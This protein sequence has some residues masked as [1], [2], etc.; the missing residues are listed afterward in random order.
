MSQHSIYTVF[1][2]AYRTLMGG[3]DC[4]V[5][6]EFCAVD[7]D[8]VLNILKAEGYL[9]W[10]EER[11]E[12]TNRFLVIEPYRDV[13]KC[14]IKVSNP[15]DRSQSHSF[16]KEVAII[17]S[18]PTA[19]VILEAIQGIEARLKQYE[20]LVY[21]V[22]LQSG[23]DVFGVT[24]EI[25]TPHNDAIRDA[26]HNAYIRW[27]EKYH[28]RARMMGS[29]GMSYWNGHYARPVIAGWGRVGIETRKGEADVAK[30]YECKRYTLSFNN[31]A[32]ENLQHMI[33]AVLIQC[34]PSLP[35]NAELTT[36]DSD[37]AGISQF[38]EISNT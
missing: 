26:V 18:R 7:A 2:H 21:Q 36:S 32:Q 15:A 6:V 14:L 10:S 19:A 34:A 31:T 27:M 30:S 16:F 29:S 8:E 17:D 28:P 13:A 37:D 24:L 22:D 33:D 23:C 4:N 3:V 38:K 20:V 35:V 12:S 1:K 11:I 25:E 9:T 5:T